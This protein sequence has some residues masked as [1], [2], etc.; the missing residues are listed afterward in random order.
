MA[1]TRKKARPAPTLSEY[2]AKEY[3]RLFGEPWRSWFALSYPSV[4]FAATAPALGRLPEQLPNTDEGKAKLRQAYEERHGLK[5]VEELEADKKRVSLVLD[6]ARR[7]L[8]AVRDLR[9]ALDRRWAPRSRDDDHEYDCENASTVGLFV[10]EKF[11]DALPSWVLDE[12][13]P[14]WRRPSETK[15][16]ALVRM[17]SD[18]RTARQIAIVSL[19]CGERPN[20]LKL[21]PRKVL[22]AEI[23]AIKKAIKRHKERAKTDE[24]ADGSE[25]ADD[26]EHESRDESDDDEPGD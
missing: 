1:S 2:L 8:L 5:E 23:E 20:A 15:R 25:V 24:S 14:L 9:V 13:P 26:G 6:E 3:E 21:E 17:M 4:G 22:L 10:L 18:T 16:G 11:V 7:A 12:D 19:L